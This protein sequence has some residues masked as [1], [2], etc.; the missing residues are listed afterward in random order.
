MD[1]TV[2]GL[3]YELAPGTGTPLVYVHGWLG[4]RESWKQVDAQL[5][6]DAPRLFYDQRCHGESGCD[7]FTIDDLADDLDSV[8]TATGLEQPV[9]AGHSMGGMVAL[10]HALDTPV[11]GVFLVGT[12]ASTPEPV[13]RSV[14]WFRE[15]L[16][17]VDRAD[18]AE[19]IIDNYTAAG[20]PE[21]VKKEARQQ[22]LDAP[23]EPVVHGLDAMLQFDIRE[24]LPP[25]VPVCVVGG[26]QDRAITPA[27]VEELAALLNVE[28]VWLDAAHDLLHEVP[29]RVAAV[30]DGFLD[31]VRQG[32]NV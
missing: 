19:G 31:R 29:E 3:V 9:V 15:N 23:R 17:T 4:S 25:D 28:P 12:C 5:E 1:R 26:E 18:W 14:R 20:T 22:L 21:A 8:I 7:P 27:K 13:N 2:D 11:A 24:R 30:L 10:T 32:G 16:D 6:T